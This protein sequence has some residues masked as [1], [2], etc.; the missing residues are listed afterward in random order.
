MGFFFFFI[1][2]QDG[3]K[4]DDVRSRG[5]GARGARAGCGDERASEMAVVTLEMKI[6]GAKIGCN[7]YRGEGLKAMII[8][9]VS[10]CLSS[11]S[12]FLAKFTAVHRFASS[13]S[14]SLSLCLS[15]SL[16][17]SISVSLS[18]YLCF[19]VSVS[20]CLSVSLSLS[21]SLKLLL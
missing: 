11:L 13:F 7:R 5:E 8:P 21:L 19:S 20:V 12:R 10:D 3:G 4:T 14:L 1:P 17:L 18:L 9:L 2:E 6:E 16:C 15:V